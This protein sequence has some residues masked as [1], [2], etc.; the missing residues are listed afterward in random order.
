MIADFNEKSQGAPFDPNLWKAY[1]RANV[2]LTTHCDRC[3]DAVEQAKLE[4]RRRRNAQS[5][6]VQTREQD[7]SSDEEEGGPI[8]DALVVPRSSPEGRIMSKWLT[9]ARK[10]L[11]GTFPRPEARKVMEDY[12]RRMHDKALRKRLKP[13][14][15][16]LRSKKQKQQ[17]GSLYVTAAT[18]AIAQKW[19]MQARNSLGERRLKK[20]ADIY[21]EVDRAVANM[22]EKDD[23]F[24]TSELRTRGENLSRD[25]KNLREDRRN[26]SAQTD[27]KVRKMK[28]ELDEYERK[29]RSDVKSEKQRFEQH[30]KT[31]RANVMKEFE[32]RKN[33]IELHRAE[34]KKVFDEESKK[35]S[36][37]RLKEA[38]RKFEKELAEYDASIRNERDR[39]LKQFES[40]LSSEREKL[41]KKHQDLDQGIL[42]RKRDLQNKMRRLRDAELDAIKQR[43][44][45]WRKK[46]LVWLS[47]ANKKFAKK[48]EADEEH[49]AK[50]RA[51][52]RRK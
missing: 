8:F 4:A 46:A 12:K 47:E 50:T 22:P 17:G 14:T 15:S 28:E 7:I 43:E 45:S 1:F 3:I 18:R 35:L 36:E 25:G 24:F 21:T 51:S 32:R 38:T 27:V 42:R 52:R 23:W 13:K 19:L 10:L 40:H 49:A 39:L 9:A 34:R 11:G 5:E 16:L 41:S 44:M 6:A 30:E 29:T 26:V 31:E 37:F 48:Q 33:D 20:A 2:K